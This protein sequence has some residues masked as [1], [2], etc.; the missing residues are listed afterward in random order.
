MYREDVTYYIKIKDDTSRLSWGDKQQLA[1][2]GIRA[3]AG[4]S[5][6]QLAEMTGVSEPLIQKLETGAS[7]AI[8]SGLMIGLCE[9]LGLD[10]TAF[11]YEILPIPK[12]VLRNA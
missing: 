5:R 8:D 9:V 6:R 4:L 1:L 2:L 3:A 12:A 7:K 10:P 11:G